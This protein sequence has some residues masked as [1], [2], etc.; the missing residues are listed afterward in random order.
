MS[1]FPGA[2]TNAQLVAKTKAALAKYGYGRNTLLATSFCCDEVNRPLEEDLG[3]AFGNPFIMGGL[4][5][6]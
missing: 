5:G 1:A 4:A 3:K 6:E 2:Q